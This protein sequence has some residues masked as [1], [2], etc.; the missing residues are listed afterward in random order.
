MLCELAASLPSKQTAHLFSA[1]ALTGSP[2][3]FGQIVNREILAAFT[4]ASLGHPA[5]GSETKPL[6]DLRL[7][8]KQ[9]GKMDS[10]LMEMLSNKSDLLRAEDYRPQGARN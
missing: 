2:S 9:S 4:N 6:S 8:T 1:L 10:R 3:V 5:D 7:L